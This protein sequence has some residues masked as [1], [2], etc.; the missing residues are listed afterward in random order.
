MNCAKVKYS[1]Q[2]F[3]DFAIQQIK[4]TSKRTKIPIRSYLCHI[5][6]AW[7]LTSR[8]DF[9]DEKI[10]ELN[11]IIKQLKEEIAILK[12]QIDK[13]LNAKVLIDKKVAQQ[14]SQIIQLQGTIRKLQYESK[15]LINKNIQLQ[16][17]INGTN[18]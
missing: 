16:K 14:N 10:N 12:K 7:H 6:N 3:A 13:K 11:Q 4:K 17:Q 5:C 2:E 15:D 1:S 18:K 9:K 8:A